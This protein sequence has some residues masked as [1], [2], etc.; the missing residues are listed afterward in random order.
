MGGC[1]G[2]GTGTGTQ[3]RGTVGT[4]TNICGTVPLLKSRRVTNPDILGQESR[5]VPLSLFKTTR[6]FCPGA[7]CVP[8]DRDRS[9]RDE[10]DREKFSRDKQDRD[11]Q[12][13]D[14]QDRDKISQ[15]CPIPSLFSRVVY[16]WN[17][18]FSNDCTITMRG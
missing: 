2:I 1:P 5:S 17:L 7:F 13:R 18:L 4:G 10:Q 9:L 15:E 8:W 12:D 3:S 11:K 6:K 16:C 14:K